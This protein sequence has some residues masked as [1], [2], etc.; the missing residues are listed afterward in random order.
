MAVKIRL[1]RAGRK[2]RPMWRIVAID[3]RRARDGAHLEK[4]GAYDPLRHEVITLNVDGIKSWVAKGAQCSDAV[5][6]IMRQY[7]PAQS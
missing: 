2:N 7:N 5:R 4:L 6:K 3:S 1:S